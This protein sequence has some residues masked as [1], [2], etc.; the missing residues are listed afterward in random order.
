MLLDL[1]VDNMA[2]RTQLQR[3]IQGYL[4]RSEG[5]IRRGHGDAHETKKE[6][7]SEMYILALKKTMVKPGEIG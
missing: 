2:P 7:S 3:Q 1:E 5:R 6:D 4:E